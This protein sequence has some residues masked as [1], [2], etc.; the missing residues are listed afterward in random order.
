MIHYGPDQKTPKDQLEEL[1]KLN[2][3]TLFYNKV[4][5]VIGIATLTVSIAGLIIAILS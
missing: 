4:I 3:S 2:S 1:K 5:I